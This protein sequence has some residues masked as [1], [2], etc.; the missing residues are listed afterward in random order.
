M[1]DP[2]SLARR[3]LRRF[4]PYEAAS[5]DRE[6][7]RLHANES[8]WR[9]DW[10]DSEAGLNRY[11]DPRPAALVARLA[12]LYDVPAEE[13]LLTRG[14]DDAID[15]LVRT[16]CEA[17]RDR[18]VVCP[19]TF[20]MYAVAA[21]L[22]GAEVDEV[23]LDAEADF[24]LDTD[25]VTDAGRSAKLVFLC[26]PNNPTGNVIT[27]DEVRA[28]CRSME[29]R[30]LVVVD[31]AYG[32]FATRQTLA[33]LRRECPN[34]VL[35][36]TLSKAYALAGARLGVL[37][38]DPDLVRL[39]RA[40]LPPYPVP[41][42]SLDAAQRLLLP[43]PVARARAE[44]AATIE[45]RER[46]RTELAGSPA[47]VRIWPS[48]GN[49]LLIRC[50]DAAA[51]IEACARAKLLIRD[52][53]RAPGLDNCVRITVGDDAQNERLVAAIAESVPEASHG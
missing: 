38:G 39:L 36:R 25:A 5:P 44:V 8:A 18:V 48:A 50:R 28:L 16:M 41:S 43:G 33:S 47:V 2:V 52:F 19:P 30:G 17:G 51:V 9:H 6:A 1:T 4:V 35:L 49:F 21:R 53:S 20:G 27:E 7:A 32:E 26:S 42:P 34:L 31:E 24:A 3:D 40:V 23:P 45:R 22:Q 10:D 29:D 13:L 14:S 11:P 15:V 37:I 12:A 46:L